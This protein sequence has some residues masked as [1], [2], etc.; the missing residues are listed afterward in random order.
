MKYLNKYKSIVI[1]IVAIASL[2]SCEKELTDLQPIDLIPAQNAIQNMDDVLA[3]VNGVY[4]TYAGRRASYVSSYMTDEVR[5]G[6]G[7]EYRNVG[8][9]LFNWIHVND[10]QDWR[11]G[12]NGG[13]WTNFYTV[14]DRAN[15]IL[16]YMQA[17]P[18][19]TP[20]EAALKQQYRG[21][22]LAMRAFAHLELLKWYGATPQYNP[23]GLGIV[24][25]T[26]WAKGPTTFKPSRSA[27]SAAVAQIISDLNAARDLIPAS[28]TDISRITRNAVI[29]ALARVALLTGDWSSVV[30]NA[31][32]VINAQP[33]STGAAYANIW[34]TRILPANQSSEVIWK[35]NVTNANLGAAVGSLWQD[36]G[37]GA[38]QASASTKLVNTF[39]PINDARFSLFFQTFPTRTLIKKYGVVLTNP[40]NNENFQYDIKMMRTSELLLARA[41]AHA[42]MNNLIPANQDLAALRAARISGYTH[43]NINDKAQLIAAIMEERYKELCYEGHRYFDL[44]RRALPITRLL[45]DVVNVAAI[46]ELPPSNFR[47]IL[48]IPQQEVFANPNMQQNPG[49]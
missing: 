25:M 18:T 11:D 33:I 12:E 36:V 45:V 27:Q 5:L 3:A 20:A 7:T 8:N 2:S 34:T 47:Y 9:I 31:T 13:G 22:M 32:T 10:S 41:E 28:F 23:S 38:V 46:T 35:L 40:A 42:E 43:T 17:V 1:G 44:K 21:E 24:V 16:D 30:T 26:D 19:N 4:G 49:Y 48:P 39:D 29:G 6:T 14:I 37:S 15:R